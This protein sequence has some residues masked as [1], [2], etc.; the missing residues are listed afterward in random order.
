MRCVSPYTSGG[1]N[2]YTER[3]FKYD[4]IGKLSDETARD[5]IAEPA[6]DLG[7]DYEEQAIMGILKWSQGY[8]FFIQ[9]LC[10]TVWEYTERD[11]ISLENVERVIATFLKNLDDNFS[12]SDMS[13][14]QK[15][16][17][18]FCLQW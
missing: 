16:S 14:V 9:E 4:Q 7:V 12:K 15:R 18:T 13:A 1:G 10:N 5:T 17:M 6:K 2:S 3:L 11:L 8:P